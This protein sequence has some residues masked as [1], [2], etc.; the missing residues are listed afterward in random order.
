M[1]QS[2][3]E[4]QHDQLAA[5]GFQLGEA[6]AQRRALRAARQDGQRVGAV[7]GL[8]RNAVGQDV[9]PAPADDVERA[10]AGK[11]YQPGLA[12]AARGVEAARL[13]PDLEEGVVRGVRRQR[14]LAGDAQRD[15]V[16]PRGEA[17]I[18]PAQRRPVP[19]RAA[20]EEMGGIVVRRGGGVGQGASFGPEAPA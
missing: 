17:F 12:T 7:V 2:L 19:F 6:A 14:R 5:I 11:A 15:A 20:A 10:I 18:E 4:G 8:L 3:H 1:R 9:A 13:L 16:Q